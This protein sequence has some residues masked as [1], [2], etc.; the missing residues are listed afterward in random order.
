MSDHFNGD[1]FFNPIDHKDKSLWDVLKWQI[2]RNA[3]KWPADQKNETKSAIPSSLKIGEFALT[4]VNHST[5]LI[6]LQTEKKMVNIL[7]DPVFSDRTSPV[8]F[9]GPKRVRPPGM[10]LE[11]LPKI[12]VV[13]VSHNHYDHMDYESLKWLNKKFSPV[14]VA[15]LGNAKYL[16]FTEKANIQERDWNDFVELPEFALKVNIQRAHHWSR[17]SLTDTNKALWCSFV[18]E[19]K[20]RAIYFAGDTG[21][22]EHFKET[23]KK[24]PKIDLALLPIGAYEPRWFMRDAHMNP[25]DAVQAHKDL[26]PTRSIG[27][28][29]GTFPLT[30]EGIDEPVKALDKAKS[31]A[32]VDNFDVLKEGQTRV[33]VD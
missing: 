32:K 2:N 4:F 12:D 31:E 21:Y 3:V 25:E 16:D 20:E 33:F 11:E 24:F 17:R 9:A 26:S 29:F 19:S 10:A 30:D 28:H 18:I 13:V 7:T 22:K 23:K 6:Q 15:P 14:F 27:I 5:F 8:S 1:T